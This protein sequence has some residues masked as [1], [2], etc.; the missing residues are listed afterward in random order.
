MQ[1]AK[2]IGGVLVA[3][4]T[5]VVL[6]MSFVKKDGQGKTLFQRLTGGSGGGDNFALLQTNLGAKPNADGSII[7]VKFG[8]GKYAAQFYKDN[9]RVIFFNDL[10]QIIG[11]GKYEDGGKTIIMDSGK[12][13][14]GNSV[15]D[16]LLKTV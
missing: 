15:W 13:I 4:G 8:G 12:N 6:Y 14:S 7:S 5:G 11:K 10:K 9:G 2:L 1:H 3:A 16:N